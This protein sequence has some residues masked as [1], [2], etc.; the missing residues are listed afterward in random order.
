LVSVGLVSL[1]VLLGLGMKDFCDR[2]WKQWQRF[3]IVISSIARTGGAYSG[4]LPRISTGGSERKHV[5]HAGSR[6]I[7][8]RCA[9][10]QDLS[11]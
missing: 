10:K 3:R 4:R 5:D 1:F 7:G 11:L 2:V 8:K 9:T 6:G